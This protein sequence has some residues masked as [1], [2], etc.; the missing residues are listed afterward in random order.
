MS[1]S[2][3]T[4]L[5]ERLAPALVEGARLVPSRTGELTIEVGAADWIATA[6]ALRDRFGFE[7]L[8]D[9]C[10]VDYSVWGI[11]E[12]K[13][14]SATG[15]GYNRAASRERWMAAARGDARSEQI[16]SRFAVVIHLLSLTHNERVRVRGWCTD[17]DAP[18]MP[19]LVDVWASANWYEREAFDLFG[20]LFD[21]HPDLR[22]LL[23]DY[24]FI[25]HPFR[26]D[27][28]LSGHVQVRYDPARG[29]V[30]YEPVDIE[31]RTLVP[32]VIRQD[33]RYEEAL[34]GAGS[35]RDVPAATSPDQENG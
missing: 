1:D 4:S 13:G 23:T 18:M 3:Q 32:K 24:G 19:S 16:R 5:A 2:Q 20:I 29:R 14:Q 30:A 34:H 15:T 28:P 35:F 9:L 31:P 8:M 7:M 21:G 22:R 10:G 26:K 11:D 12:W 27:F 33:H 17:D 6:T 25:G